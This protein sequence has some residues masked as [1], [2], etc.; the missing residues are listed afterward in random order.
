MLAHLR[1]QASAC[2]PRA[3]SPREVPMRPLL[4]SICVLALL[5][6][7]DRPPRAEPE[8]SPAANRELPT[9]L[10]SVPSP[11]STFG[12]LTD[13]ASSIDGLVDRFVAALASGDRDRGD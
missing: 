4:V 8:P 1:A 13:G 7:P 9:A 10:P 3:P 12:R 11:E 2:P 5:A 6:T